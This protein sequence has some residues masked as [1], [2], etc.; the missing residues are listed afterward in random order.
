MNGTV[1]QILNKFKCDR[2]A[3]LADLAAVLSVPG[4]CAL[5]SKPRLARMLVLTAVAHCSKNSLDFE[6]LIKTVKKAPLNFSDRV[7][8]ELRGELIL[9]LSQHEPTKEVVAEFAELCLYHWPETDWLWEEVHD[10]KYV[11]DTLLEVICDRTTTRLGSEFLKK[12]HEKYRSCTEFWQAF[13]KAAI[14]RTVSGKGEE[15]KEDP[16]DWNSYMT[17]WAVELGDVNAEDEDVDLFV[18]VWATMYAVA[19][20]LAVRDSKVTD[21]FLAILEKSRKRKELNC[22]LACRVFAS[23]VELTDAKAL[24]ATERVKLVSE[25]LEMAVAKTAADSR[26]KN[27]LMFVVASKVAALENLFDD[28]ANTA[29]D[30]FVYCVARSHVNAA[31]HAM[32]CVFKESMFDVGR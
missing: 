2:G 3:V 7:L 18:D 22:R 11:V 28:V 19:G 6:Q 27:V 8:A 29:P 32:N 1:D 5:T 10:A 26:D 14:L 16:G 20:D 25:F 9:A 13:T 30:E 21:W 31:F 15:A 24:G 23:Y 17:S 4:W 12:L